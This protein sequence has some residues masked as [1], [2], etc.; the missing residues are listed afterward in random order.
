MKLAL[1]SDIHGNL[2]ALDAVLN[3][4]K[5]RKIKKIYCLGDVVDYGGSS[6]Q[7][8]EIIRKNKILSVMGNHDLNTVTLEKYQWF[9]STSK[10]ALKI[11]NKLLTEKNKKFL[12]KLPKK[13]LIENMFL[14]HASPRNN[15][16]EYVYPEAENSVFEEFFKIAKKQIIAMGHTHFPFIRKINDNLIINPGSVGQPRDNNCKASF[17]VLDN[18]TLKAKIIRIDYD[19]KKAADKILKIGMPKILAEGLF[20]G[21]KGYSI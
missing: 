13:L 12:L 16:Y 1:I 6:N 2:E 3:E 20:D 5:K 11:T 17:C 15:L 9:N 7:C 18:I 14:V 10:K 4:I 21:F 8:I 19:I